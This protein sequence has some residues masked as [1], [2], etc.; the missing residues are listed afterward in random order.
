M[1]LMYKPKGEGTIAVP[2]Q[3]LQWS[4]KAEAEHI[5]SN[6]GVPTVWKLVAESAI[7]NNG[8]PFEPIDAVDYTS[9]PEWH[10]LR[11]ALPFK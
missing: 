5:S 2:I 3:S 8:R 9:F 7:I 10:H 6:A 11:Q 4:W 1:Y